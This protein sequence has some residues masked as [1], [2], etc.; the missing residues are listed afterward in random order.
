VGVG[1]VLKWAAV[2]LLRS[3]FTVF[4]FLAIALGFAAFIWGAVNMQRPGLFTL[5]RSAW[6]LSIIGLIVLVLFPD[7]HKIVNRA[8]YPS[9]QPTCYSWLRQPT[10]AAELKR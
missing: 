10:Q 1:L 5:V 3:G 6:L 2:A 7:K 4:G 8:A 9:L